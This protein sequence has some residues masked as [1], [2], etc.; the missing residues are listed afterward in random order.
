MRAY[1]KRAPSISLYGCGGEGGIPDYRF[2]FPSRCSAGARGPGVSVCFCLILFFFFRSC[3]TL[4]QARLAPRAAAVVVVCTCLLLS[5]VLPFFFLLFIF[6]LCRATRVSLFFLF[7][8]PPSLDRVCAPFVRFSFLF[9]FSRWGAPPLAAVGC[10]TCHATWPVWE[11][12]LIVITLDACAPLF[13]E[14][15]PGA[16]ARPALLIGA[17]SAPVASFQSEEGVT[18]TA[19]RPSDAG[20]RIGLAVTKSWLS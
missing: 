17:L 10:L 16:A 5:P 1:K 13:G 6:S 19:A 8:F 3:S 14:G 18:L 11:V 2:F 9:L 7:L 15:K 20:F 12:L 4:S